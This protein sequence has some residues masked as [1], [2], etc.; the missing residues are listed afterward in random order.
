MEVHRANPEDEKGIATLI[1]GDEKLLE[2]RFG[3]FNVQE[4]IENSIIAITASNETGEIVAFAAFSNSPTP[5]TGD[6]RLA[7]NKWAEWVRETFPDTG[8]GPRNTLWL[9]FFAAGSLYEQE[10]ID[11]ILHSAFDTFAHV[12]ALLFALGPNVTAFTPVNEPEIFE[13]IEHKS[14]DVKMLVSFAINYR[15]QVRIRSARVEDHDDLT[16]I[17]NQQSEILTENY[18][19]FYLTRVIEAQSKSNQVL[20]ADINNKPVGLMSLTSD[21][22]TKILAD[23]FDLSPY[24]NFTKPTVDPEPAGLK[25]NANLGDA[26]YLADLS[27]FEKDSK[28]EPGTMFEPIFGRLYNGLKSVVVDKFVDA[29]DLEKLKE[30]YDEAEQKRK[31]VEADAKRAAGEEVPDDDDDDDEV[32]MDFKTAWSETLPNYLV[33]LCLFSAAKGKPSIASSIDNKALPA[34]AA[35][36]ISELMNAADAPAD[37][38]AFAAACKRVGAAVAQKDESLSINFLINLSKYTALVGGEAK[39]VDFGE[40]L[41][42]ILEKGT[43]H[44][45]PAEG[46]EK[47]K[48]SAEKKADDS[49]KSGTEEEKTKKMVNGSTNTPASNVMCITLYCLEE[50]YEGLGEAFLGEAFRRYPDHDYCILTLPHSSPE[51]PLLQHFTYVSPL[52]SN[53]FS[54]SLYLLH[55]ATAFRAPLTVRW[56]RAGDMMHLREMTTAMENKSE[57]LSAARRGLKAKMSTSPTCACLT[58]EHNDQFI[59]AVVVDIEETTKDVDWL[60][61]EYAV[62]EVISTNTFP[63][64]AHAT[65]L[66]YLCDPLFSADKQFVLSEVMRILNKGAL[67]YRVYPLHYVQDLLDALVQVAPRKRPSVPGE[68]K[69]TGEMDKPLHDAKTGGMLAALAEE[70]KDFALYVTSVRLLHEPRVAVNARIVVYGATPCALS[71]LEQLLL[72]PGANFRSLTIITPCGVEEQ[73]S[74]MTGFFPKEAD[75]THRHLDR[76]AVSARVKVLKSTISAMDCKRKVVVLADDKLVP[77]DY[78]VLAPGL[79][80]ETLAGLNVVSQKFLEEQKRKRQLAEE[81]ANKENDEEEVADEKSEK[82]EGKGRGKEEEEQ[83]EDEE[84]ESLSEPPVNEVQGVVSVKGNASTAECLQLLEGL[85]KEGKLGSSRQSKEAKILVYGSTVTALTMIRGLLNQGLRPSSIFWLGEDSRSTVLSQNQDNLDLWHS[86]NTKVENQVIRRLNA[87]GVKSLGLAK[88]ETVR[89]EDGK[90][91]GVH[92]KPGRGRREKYPVFVQSLQHEEMEG[93]WLFPCQILLCC[94]RP[95][96]DRTLYKAITNNS[97]VYDGRLVVDRYFR[98]ENPNVLAAGSLARLSRAEGCTT[99]LEC[100][101]PVEV[102]VRLAET[103]IDSIVWEQDHKDQRI[104][105]R[106]YQLPKTV[107]CIY[108][109]EINFFHGHAPDYDLGKKRAGKTLESDKNGV[110]QQLVFGKDGV[111]KSFTY[112]GEKSIDTFKMAGLIGLP[113]TYMNGTES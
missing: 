53:T 94:G 88:I 65:I 78:L 67:H 25:E 35:S 110:Y 63:S 3:K 84:M 95:D 14:G 8:L 112:L 61:T 70:G 12:D 19:E 44:P 76:L 51:I 106:P 80:D 89:H 60:C 36:A 105:M 55:R 37:V 50:A 11:M 27:A 102:G 9:S 68:G 6:E 107:D 113:F 97:L 90:L 47:L 10:A 108:P 92:F 96:V 17:F 45:K 104:P 16:P 49:V 46:A 33:A 69:S 79:Q 52:P 86:G 54:H 66:Y 58:L 81:A 93:M 13:E 75:Y 72:N 73:D 18:G 74:G 77:Y 26:A 4:L 91:S 83:A 111:L 39:G 85:R 20:V 1:K 109:G 62:D 42:N 31:Q 100:Y 38:A 32:E 7:P 48:E 23:C 64:S 87:L 101:N 57:I 103:L 98:T 24:N 41:K 99:P 56:S 59:G 71:F 29:I 2:K 30:E 43:W 28:K 21:I 15:P 22:D 5:T 82:D 34:N 40:E